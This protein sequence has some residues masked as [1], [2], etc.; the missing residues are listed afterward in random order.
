MKML[1]V[2]V[3]G[4]EGDEA[5]LG[6]AF[7]VAKRF[8]SHVEALHVRPDPAELLHATSMAFP[9]ALRKSVIEVGEK[10]AEEMAKLARA[11]FDAYCESHDINV[12]DKPP[13]DEGVSCAWV[14][15]TGKES[16]GVAL[17]GRLNDLTVLA[18][19]LEETPAP[20]TLE[21][22]L[23]NSGKPVLVLPPHKLDSIG[24][25]VAICWNGSAVAAKAVAA[26]RHFLITAEK[27][28]VLSLGQ[29]RPG[30]LTVQDLVDHLA[31][32]DVQAEVREIAD[33]AGGTAATILEE[34]RKLDSDLLV[35]GAYGT[36]MTRE[37]ILG[38]VTRHMLA[39]AEIPL[40]MVH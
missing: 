32:H 7:E 6:A 37:L 20:A 14:E 18:R 1:L 3:R 17:R 36:S 34:A 39:H 11:N 26:A 29:T 21:A 31:W 23:M 19:P 5:L 40:L 25:R 9:G 16:L 2:P 33:K 12:L 30:R 22:A 28:T 24:R 27:V 4:V 15:A 10:Q 35:L 13:Y 38:G 8:N